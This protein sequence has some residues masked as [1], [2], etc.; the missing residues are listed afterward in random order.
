MIVKKKNNDSIIIDNVVDRLKIFHG[1]KRDIELANIFDLSQ[2]DFSQ[3]KKRGT[4]L[5]M[6]IDHAHNESVNLHWLLT[7]EGEMH[8]HHEKPLSQVINEQEGVIQAI[9]E[10]LSS[11]DDFII[12]SLKERLK[13]YKLAL[14]SNR[15]RRKLEQRLA[16]VEKKLKEIKGGGGSPGERPGGAGAESG[17][18]LNIKEGS[19]DS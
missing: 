16:T 13:D 19:S 1:F 4:L 3:R 11:G 6:L 5:E 8:V 9:R 7:G 17:T 12:R 2:A 18:A 15:A 14:A 10:I